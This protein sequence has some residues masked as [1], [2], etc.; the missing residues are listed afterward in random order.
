M[1][2]QEIGDF[3]RASP[4]VSFRVHTSDGKHVDV[5]HPEMAW[6]T[7][8]ALLVAH[9]VNDP[10]RDIPYDYDSVSPLHIVGLEPLVQA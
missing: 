2:P 6:R 4:F 3:L 7:R 5:K 10:T 8:M 1:N 9:P